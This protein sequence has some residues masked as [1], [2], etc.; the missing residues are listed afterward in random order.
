MHSPAKQIADFIYPNLRIALL[1]GNPLSLLGA[2]FT[3]SNAHKHTSYVWACGLGQSQKALRASILKSG[4]RGP[5]DL[6]DW[7]I[8]LLNWD[9]AIM[10]AVAAKEKHECRHANEMQAL[11]IL[12]VAWSNINIQI[13]MDDIILPIHEHLQCIGNCI[14]SALFGL[15]NIF[16]LTGWLIMCMN[17]PNHVIQ[18]KSFRSVHFRF[19]S[20]W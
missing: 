4:P 1:V 3:I 15:N 14:K 13:F 11:E 17:N 12:T 16:W 19:K 10:I 8:L 9:S 20:G 18:S 6:L 7:K 2:Y 5:L